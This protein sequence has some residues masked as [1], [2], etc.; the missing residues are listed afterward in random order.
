MEY[1]IGVKEL[2]TRPIIRR[3]FDE[4]WMNKMTDEELAQW[5]GEV[6]ANILEEG[7][8]GFPETNVAQMTR[9][10]DRGILYKVL[11]EA[12]SGSLGIKE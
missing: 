2:L 4:E 11:Q 7:I 8:T 12:E 9:F 10:I 5:D 6:Y 1:T 3:D